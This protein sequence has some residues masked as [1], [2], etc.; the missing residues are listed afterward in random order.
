MVES[1]I[2]V[3][4]LFGFACVILYTAMKMFKSNLELDRNTRNREMLASAY[5]DGV[6]VMINLGFF[7]FALI[8]YGVLV[9]YITTH[10]SVWFS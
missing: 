6:D 4:I 7:V 9:Y 10:W 3:A 1:T 8:G 2:V 5:L